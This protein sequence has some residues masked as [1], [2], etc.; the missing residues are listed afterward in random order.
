[1]PWRTALCHSASAGQ[2]G[3]CTTGVSDG[4]STNG[5]KHVTKE[6]KKED[7]RLHFPQHNTCPTPTLD[8]H[9]LF[10][11][12]DSALVCRVGIGGGGG[13]RSM[14][15]GGGGGGGGAS[16]CLLLCGWLAR[17]LKLLLLRSIG[18]ERRRHGFHVH[19]SHSFGRRAYTSNITI[20]QVRVFVLGTFTDPFGFKSK[21]RP[22][23]VSYSDFTIRNQK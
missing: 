18:L 3:K 17:L 4:C 19:G 8:R 12:I 11:D 2:T 14:S 22:W 20:C 6:K 1:M 10:S 5:L 7:C 9:T 23:T 16:L 21:T 13:P 15:A